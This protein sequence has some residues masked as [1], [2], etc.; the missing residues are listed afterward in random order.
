M[1]EKEAVDTIN[2]LVSK[3]LQE[4]LDLAAERA[5]DAALKA[6]E[7]YL[8]NRLTKDDRLVINTVIKQA[9]PKEGSRGPEVVPGFVI[10]VEHKATP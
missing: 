9:W 10:D 4:K 6:T 3:T 1:I 7:A 8:E 5:V 2:S